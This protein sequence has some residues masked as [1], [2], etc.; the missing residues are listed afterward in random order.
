M[1]LIG[2]IIGIFFLLMQ[3]A[4][5]KVVDNV[6]ISA[7]GN[8]THIQISHV[9]SA[10]TTKIFQLSGHNPRI[11]V[12]F[13]DA[14]AAFRVKDSDYVG[15]IQNI[16]HAKRGD[17]G[18]RLV[19]D[20]IPNAELTF[21]SVEASAVRL[22]VRG[23]GGNFPQAAPSASAAA[24]LS[25]APIV[26]GVPYPRLKPGPIKTVK[27]KP[28]VVIDAGHGGRDP[29]TIGVSGTHEKIITLKASQELRRQLVATGRYE[30][31]LTRSDDTY[32]DLEERL[33]IARVRGADLFIS[34][35]A[36]ATKTKSA[37][38]ASVYTLA[39]RA[40]HRTQTVMN[41][42]NWIMDVD[43]AEQSAPVGDILVDLAQRNTTSQSEKFAD[44]LI[45]ELS[46]TTRLIGNTH[47][48]AGLFVL[49]APD[50]PAVLLE[51]GFM[52]NKHDEA[53]LRS[54]AH[55]KKVVGSVV[56]AINTYFDTQ[57]S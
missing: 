15:H 39:D 22:V 45:G 42:Q 20:M 21:K 11:V 49:L 35:H 29:G 47:R 28:V 16:R 12:D 13:D 36:D 54:A 7:V 56:T 4:A 14:D 41:S 37:R 32:V 46:G 51:L 23:P 55:R 57:K 31:V 27:A 9:G 44:V 25:A 33:R 26:R 19:L 38:G 53:L 8:E 50:V 18:L 40:K 17:K 43:L 30:V 5:A 48:R 52:S 24:A 10:Q 6:A 1:R 34:L 3:V 2:T